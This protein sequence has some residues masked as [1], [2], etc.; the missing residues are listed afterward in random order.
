MYRER[1]KEFV[2]WHTLKDAILCYVQLGL[3]K[4]D[5]VKQGDDLYWKGDKDLAIYEKY[6]E[7]KFIQ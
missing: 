6:F 4:A 5:I 1:E 2:D 3:V 7:E